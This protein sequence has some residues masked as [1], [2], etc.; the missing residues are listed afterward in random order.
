MIPVCHLETKRVLVE[1]EQREESILQIAAVVAIL[2]LH[3]SY[4]EPGICLLRI[5]LASLYT[6]FVQH[7]FVEA[8]TAPV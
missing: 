1:T 6:V 4:P 2:D 5:S 7:Y 3:Y 8:K